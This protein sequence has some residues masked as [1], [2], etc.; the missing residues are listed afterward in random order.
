MFKLSLLPSDRR[1][2]ILFQQ[3]AENVVKMAKE[4]RDLVHVWQNVKERAGILA[5]LERDGDAITHEIMASLHRSF[6]TPF[7]REDI[8]SLAHSLDDIADRIQST[9]DTMFLYRIEHSTAPAKELADI[10][11]QAAVEVQIAVH[12]IGG[13]IDHKKLLK[14]CVEIN[15]LENLGDA[16]YRAAVADLFADSSDVFYVVKWRE[17]YDDME[18]AIDGCEVVANVLEGIALKY[19]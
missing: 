9:A 14:Q 19:A 15:R 3:G 12:G 6:I 7:D 16:V 5:D 2:S 13:R 1:F 17:I 10:I 8:G 18:S 11:L 4:L